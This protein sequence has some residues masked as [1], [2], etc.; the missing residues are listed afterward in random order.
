[1]S[2][3]I[4]FS[5]DHHITATAPQAR[6]ESDE[7]WREVQVDLMQQVKKIVGDNLYINAGDLVHVYIPKDS[8]LVTSMIIDNSPPKMVI[9]AGN[10]DVLGTGR[11]L[12]KA[13]EKGAL[14]TLARS[15]KIK[16]LNDNETFEYEDYV[17]YPFNFKHKQTVEHRDV[18][19]TKKNIA[20]GH[21]ASYSKKKPFYMEEAVIAEDVVKEYPEFDL[22][23][24]GDIHE[25]FIADNKY[26]SPGSLTRR[27]INQIDHR[28]CIHS[29]DGE[30][31]ETYY[32][33][34]KP[35]SE[36]LSRAHIDK[37]EARET[38]MDDWVE[39]TQDTNVDEYDFEGGCN[40][41][42]NKNTLRDGTK[43]KLFTIIGRCS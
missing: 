16:F 8:N 21:F 23:I 32:L 34:V 38:R 20:V 15:E 17:I 2:K 37:K 26:V 35:A 10:H 11:Q 33:K 27:S 28:P 13:L 1:M 6:L 25:H 18:D 39:K 9:I 5:S 29:W 42:C 41:Y 7:E 31:I 14:G 30:K 12:D 19:S 43:D 24:V 36:C 22:F 4:Y 3:K 40:I